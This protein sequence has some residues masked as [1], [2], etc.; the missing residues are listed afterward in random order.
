MQDQGG[1]GSDVW[2]DAR[3]RMTLMPPWKAGPLPA[4]KRSGHTSRKSC[5]L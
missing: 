4:P 1:R 3:A 5:H 2:R